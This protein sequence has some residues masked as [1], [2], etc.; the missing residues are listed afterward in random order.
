MEV[1]KN[2]AENNR[3]KRNAF[4]SNFHAL[5]S[6]KNP[7]FLN[8]S[9]WNR[10]GPASKCRI[11]FLSG[12]SG[13]WVSVP[14]KTQALRTVRRSADAQLPVSEIAIFLRQLPEMSFHYLLYSS[15]NF[16]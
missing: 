8:Y 4:K 12:E 3:R 11:L 6:V 14:A 9:R 5:G 1:G 2:A 16:V 10:L 13:I 15:L 7:Q